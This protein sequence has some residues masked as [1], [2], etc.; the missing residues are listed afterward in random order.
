MI[1]LKLIKNKINEKSN[2]NILI[3]PHYREK[4]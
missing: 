2:V 4:L 1:K 3:D